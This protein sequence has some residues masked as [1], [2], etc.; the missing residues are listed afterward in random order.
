VDTAPS[1]VRKAT[2]CAVER[3]LERFCGMGVEH[4]YLL[5]LPGEAFPNM[6]DGWP[7]SPASEGKP[8]ALT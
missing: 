6:D 3:G 7:G 2:M 4:R 1:H 5:V 8:G